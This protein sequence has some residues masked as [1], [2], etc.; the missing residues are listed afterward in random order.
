M[1][2]PYYRLSARLSAVPLHC[3]SWMATAMPLATSVQGATPSGVAGCYESGCGQ[4]RSLT[5]HFMKLRKVFSQS[6]LFVVADAGYGKTHLAAQLTAES[7]DRPAGV[8]LYGRDLQASTEPR[9]PRSSGVDITESRLAC[10]EAHGIA[11]VDAASRP[12]GG[13][14]VAYRHRWL[15]RSRGP[16][17]LEEAVGGL[18]DVVAQISVCT[19][20]VHT[21]R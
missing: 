14:T 6:V 3:G 19:N 7:G 5:K 2:V 18:S 16:A 1:Q 12:A 20:C 9:R 21:S 17:R 11:A 13:Q 15:E 10:F 4:C 8:L